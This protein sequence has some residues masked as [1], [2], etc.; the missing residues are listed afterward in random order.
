MILICQ[1]ALNK[2]YPNYVFNG[3]LIGYHLDDYRNNGNRVSIPTA[4][5]VSLA[6]NNGFYGITAY[7]FYNSR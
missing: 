2:D 5:K 4:N 1:N 6:L 3:N 7:F